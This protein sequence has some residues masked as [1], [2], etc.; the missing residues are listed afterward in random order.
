MHFNK[1]LIKILSFME[2][3]TEIQADWRLIHF[4]RNTVWKRW[5]RLFQIQIQC[6]T[7]FPE[8]IKHFLRLCYVQ[9]PIYDSIYRQDS[10]PDFKIS[11]YRYSHFGGD[12]RISAFRKD[13]E[14][15]V[16]RILGKESTCTFPKSFQVLL[17]QKLS[18]FL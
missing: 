3:K 5:S 2:K 15:E 1:L 18:Q 4:C 17:Q 11:H 12:Q 14:R 9:S 10:A 6:S 13:K 8:T 16:G 7:C